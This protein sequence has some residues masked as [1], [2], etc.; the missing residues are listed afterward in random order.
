MEFTAIAENCGAISHMLEQ[1]NVPNKSY[2]A[3]R[4]AGSR[5][6]ILK[7]HKG[8]SVPDDEPI[9]P[10]QPSAAEAAE[11]L[12]RITGTRRLPWFWV[13]SKAT[14]TWPS[15]SVPCLPDGYSELLKTDEYSVAKLPEYIEQLRMVTTEYMLDAAIRDNMGLPVWYGRKLFFVGQGQLRHQ[16]TEFRARDKRAGL[17]NG[18]PFRQQFRDLYCDQQPVDLDSLSC[19]CYYDPNRDY[20]RYE[21][22]DDWSSLHSDDYYDHEFSGPAESGDLDFFYDCEEPE[23]VKEERRKEYQR[24]M[25]MHQAAL[26]REARPEW[27]RARNGQRSLEEK[28]A[29]RDKLISM[30]LTGVAQSLFSVEH[31]HKFPFFEDLVTKLTAVKDEIDW[32]NVIAE[33]SFFFAHLASG[34]ISKS[35]V[36]TSVLH[37]LKNLPVKDIAYNIHKWVKRMDN[38]QSVS[39]SGLGVAISA[40]ISCVFAM[41]FSKL[42]ADKSIDQFIMRFSRVGHLIS[43]VEKL[44]SVSKKATDL[45]VS[46]VKQCVFGYDDEAVNEMKDFNTFCDEAQ[47]LFYPGVEATLGEGEPNRTKLE[48]LCDQADGLQQV[49]DA[50]RVPYSQTERFRKWSLYVA[51]LRAAAANAAMGE[52]RPRIPPVLIHFI[53]D[54]GV[55][56]SNMLDYLNTDLLVAMGS[57]DVKDLHNLV[58]YRN[59]LNAYY[60]GYRNGTKILVC[61]DFGAAKDTITNPNPEVLETIRHTNGVP[62]RPLMA[63]LS[64]KASAVF[65]AQVIIWTSNRDTFSFDSLTNPEAIYS[66]VKLRF[67]QKV[68]PEFM[69][70]VDVYG[71]RCK[72]LDS[73]KVVAHLE[74]DPEAFR[75][76][77]LFDQLTLE[78][79]VWREVKKDLTFDE[80]S[81]ICV[82]TVKKNQAVGGEVIQDRRDYFARK[83]AQATGVAEVSSDEIFLRYVEETTR[84]AYMST[85]KNW[86]WPLGN[87]M[88]HIPLHLAMSQ[89]VKNY[90]AQELRNTCMEKFYQPDAMKRLYTEML[91]SAKCIQV[92]PGFEHQAVSSCVGVFVGK[93]E[94][95]EELAVESELDLLDMTREG[96]FRVCVECHHKDPSLMETCST[97]VR[98]LATNY[99]I[100]TAGIRVGRPESPEEQQTWRSYMKFWIWCINLGVFS[101]LLI[102]AFKW[103]F[104][105]LTKINTAIS[106]TITG[107]IS[108]VGNLFAGTS[109]GLAEVAVWKDDG[110]VWHARTSAFDDP[111]IAEHFR[112]DERF[113]IHGDAEVV[114]MTK[115][116]VMHGEAAEMQRTGQT[117]MGLFS[118]SDDDIITDTGETVG[119]RRAGKQEAYNSGAAR[120]QQTGRVETYQAGQAR[121]S[122]TGR[123]EA[124][125]ERASGSVQSL[126]D[127]NAGEVRNRVVKNIYGIMTGPDPDTLVRLGTCTILQGRVGITNRHIIASLMDYVGLVSFTK[128]LYVMKKEDLVTY[129]IPDSDL[130]MGQRDVAVFELP[131]MFPVHSSIVRYFMTPEDFSRH[132]NVPKASM[133]WCE[134]RNGRPILRYYDSNLMVAQQ[135]RFFDLQE[136]GQVLQI[137]DFYLHGF[138]TVNGDC[139]ALIIAFDPAMQNKICAMHM[140][141]FDGEH[142]TGAAVA[143]HTGVIG[144][145]LDGIRPLLKHRASLFDG[146]VPGVVSGG[147]QVEDG[148]ITLVTK[149]PEGF[150]Y[151][152]Q[153]ENP[154][155]ENTRT[156]LRKS[157]VYD[158]CGPVK[159]KPAYLAPFKQGDMVI[160]PR[161]MAMKKAAGPNMRVH[162]QFLDEALNS[163]KQK[164]NSQVRL[165]D[166]RVLSFQEAIAGIAG[167]D[168][169]PPI[170]RT[171]SP[172]Y[173]WTKIGKG[174]TR[175]LGT[176]DYVFD[177][178]DLVAAYDDGMARLRRG[179]R[180]GKFW[181]DTMK[182]ELRPIEKV[183]Q[184]KTRLFSA[185]EMVQTI[186]LRQYFDGF[187]AHMARNHTY[188]ESCVGINVYSMDWELLARRLQRKGRAVVAGDF[189]NYD[190]SLPASVIWATLDVVEDFYAK[191]PSD[192]EDMEIRTLLWLEIV[193]SIHISGK[194]V[195][196]W[197]HGQPSGCPFTSLLNSV[198][199][200]I[201]VRVVFLLC[202]EK[203]APQYCSMAAFEEHVNHNN[204]GDDDVT[205]I[206]DEILPWFN[207][208]TQAEMYATF[209]MTYTDEAK[210]GE[211][212]SHRYLEDIAF[213]KRKFRWD[214]DQA[215]HRAP[216]E[217]DTILEMPCWNKTRTDSQAALTALVLQDAVYE[218]SQHSRQIWNLHYPKLDAA[219]ST[220]Y[221]MAPCAFPTYEEANRI[222]MEKYVYR[223]K[224]SQNPVIRASDY[225]PDG[226][227][228]QIPLGCLSG[229][230]QSAEG[231]VFTSSGACVPSKNNRLCTRRAGVG[232]LS[233][234]HPEENSLATTQ[235]LT[236]Q[237]EQLQLTEDNGWKQLSQGII[238][239]VNVYTQVMEQRAGGWKPDMGMVANTAR[240]LHRACNSLITL[241]GSPGV[242]TPP[243][244]PELSAAQAVAYLDQVDQLPDIDFGVDTV[245]EHLDGIFDTPTGVAQSGLEQ[246][247]E[248]PNFAGQ[249][250]E[251]VL[252][253]EVMKIVEDGQVNVEDR[254]IS[255][256]VPEEIQCGAEDGLT[257]DIIGFLRRPVLLKSFDWTKGQGTGALISEHDFPHAWIFSNPMIQEKL[258]GFRFLRCTFVVEIQ[259]NAQPFNAGGLL[260]WFN[261]LEDDR[262]T[263]LSSAHHLGG[264]FGYPNA[265]YRCNESTACRIRIP[266]FPVMSHYDLV[267]GYGTAG[268]LHVEVLSALTGA[269]DVDGTIWCWAENIDLAMPTGIP[270]A[271]A[272][273]GKAQ[274]G[275]AEALTGNVMKMVEAVPGASLVS[276]IL[277][278][279]MDKAASVITSA[280][281]IATAFGWSKPLNSNISENMQ[282]AHVRF[283]PNATGTT[284]ARVMALDGKNTTATASDVFNT[285]A[286]EMS[287]KEIIRRPVYLTKSILRKAQ[288]AGDRVMYFPA[289]PCWCERRVVGTGETKGII[290]NETYLSYLST[291]AAFWRGPLKY[292]FVFFKTPFHSGRIRITFVPGPR[293]Q[294]TET[295][296]LAK[297]YSEIHD[298]RGKMD[299]EFTVPYS[300]NQPWRPTESRGLAQTT[301]EQ[302]TFSLI[303]QG[304]IM[305]TIVNALRGPPT[306]GDDVEFF[307]MI[308][309]GEGF[310]FAIPWV[311]PTVHPFYNW[312]TPTGK[313]QSGIYSPCG[314]GVAAPVDPTINVRGVGEVFTGFRQWLKRATRRQTNTNLP[315]T[316]LDQ[317]P[318]Q[319]LENLHGRLETPISRAVLLYRFYCGSMRWL[320]PAGTKDYEI[321]S[322]P[323]EQQLPGVSL[324]V[325]GTG[326]PIA[327]IP[328]AD[329]PTELQFPFYQLWPALPTEIASQ[330]LSF[331]YDHLPNHN[332]QGIPY[333]PGTAVVNVGDDSP[334]S[335]A[336]H[337]I[338]EDFHF[339]YLL[340]P[341]ITYMETVVS[342]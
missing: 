24:A 108:G 292:K 333:N 326:A 11:G 10:R 297:C 99:T 123:V 109:T 269:D 273:S 127:Q 129:H 188:V 212:V 258:R 304:M 277:P 112:N 157:P 291:N 334:L 72:S 31:A 289:D 158:I 142:F 60:D 34:G 201:V 216:L 339:G 185:G 115:V 18:G 222:D 63:D 322:I 155:F 239:V 280:G 237:L 66:R 46:F 199:H 255:T 102:M 205:N 285:K 19:E 248:I 284:D 215:R 17:G 234:P 196:V 182:D 39:M 288:K 82:D 250:G 65:E 272:L 23:D 263:E 84:P 254:A 156:T 241:R 45:V 264:K 86:R 319:T 134:M 335:V 78:G 116:T 238:D 37:L 184:G 217:L 194:D 249:E 22:S 15:M 43:S 68:R 173:G 2:N 342:T 251:T 75:T 300:F 117:A 266:F 81:A 192:P 341:P 224:L 227:M 52:L 148:E 25:K 236:L 151:I 44:D 180:L 320:L 6:A 13:K 159:K 317:T 338:G 256:T 88:R 299:I 7:N 282:M 324:K 114:D 8:F 110:G 323:P 190:G 143:L 259:V 147:I 21:D 131:T 107:A 51:Q 337:A 92:Y 274:A 315:F 64:G 242:V 70:E 309:G 30:R 305:V 165:S 170:N 55:G 257:N 120:S 144:A 96:Q 16:L 74:N 183:D 150:M 14:R 276:S 296:D 124:Q 219:R 95:L 128:K 287:F 140:A 332:F 232:R 211:M 279:A 225:S 178:P 230:S 195:Y 111:K 160:D 262:S 209:G 87:G 97:Q 261:P 310:Q 268:R 329:C 93:M 135:S 121:S 36:T 204:Y 136:K 168:C 206:S 218:L 125:I 176:D 298:I 246:P 83:V 308:S 226:P 198:V 57:R 49:L 207:Q 202:A 62:Y 4:I 223:G 252:Q 163:V 179:E 331:I 90:P 32:K 3:P 103:L 228:Q 161:M 293:I 73:A 76:C 130:K 40:V 318:P 145:L 126:S 47:S 295:I 193:N 69:K 91:L 321:A 247:S 29:K 105:T 98:D 203:Y 278:E 189:T 33:F 41:M 50:K 67:R 275:T 132:T 61:D 152:G 169:Y 1:T 77:M 167:D 79:T 253:Q 166:C 12:R 149:I 271:P 113:V 174:K 244:D 265:V 177:H 94:G 42:P 171:T 302:E 210:T 233:G 307:T 164:I 214:A 162:P 38:A 35:N 311:N 27:K 235:T 313:A 118:F 137:R 197:T 229:K 146:T 71:T 139:G 290:R 119:E 208:I 270:P 260:A 286:D 186:I 245:D 58:Y 187:A 200:S 100:Y 267:E 175:W 301:P 213:L 56:K 9:G 54:T 281:A 138:E 28:R 312:N 330:P 53:G 122:Q 59:P 221:H 316:F 314:G 181:T 325:G 80:M 48:R 141:G 328:A 303:P 89:W 5:F 101:T 191:A 240:S 340:G 243:T 154:V 220:I 85:G 294:A 306:V 104:R 283:A 26:V 106:N 20:D 153:V 231:E 327:I 133:V 336:Y 172:G